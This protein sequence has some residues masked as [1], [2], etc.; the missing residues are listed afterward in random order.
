MGTFSVTM[1]DNGLPEIV[2][3][4]IA[5]L[6]RAFTTEQSQ[7]AVDALYAKRWLVLRYPPAQSAPSLAQVRAPGERCRPGTVT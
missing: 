6:V 7:F 5:P 1:L 4:L 2:A 3:K